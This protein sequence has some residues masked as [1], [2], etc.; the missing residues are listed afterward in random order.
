M[1][2]FDLLSFLMSDSK[3]NEEVGKSLFNLA[4]MLGV[5]VLFKYYWES[6]NPLDLV[7]SLIVIFLFYIMGMVLIKNSNKKD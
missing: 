7:I 6:D 4:N 5:L 2:L 3:V 1:K